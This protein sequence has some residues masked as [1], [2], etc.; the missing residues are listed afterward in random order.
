MRPILA[1]AFLLASSL[2]AQPAKQVLAELNWARQQPKAAAEVLKGW[3]PLFE[4]GR[5]LAFPGEPR[6]RTQEGMA[7]VKEAIAFLEKQKPLPPLS[8]SDRLA[9][10]AEDLARD[11][12]QHGGLGH[13]GS[14]GSLPWDRI[15]R[16][17]T[18]DGGVG[19]VATYGT[20]GEPGDPRRA[21]LALIVDDGVA[22]R[23][24]R[25]VIF[26]PSYTLAGAAWGP[27][28]IYTHMVIVDFATGFLRDVEPRPTQTRR[29]EF[30]KQLVQELNL[31]RQDPKACAAELR[32]W[33]T[34]FQ[35]GRVL[36]FPGERPMQ[37]AEGAP[38]VLEAIALLESRQSVEPV[39]WSEDLAASAEERVIAD[40]DATSTAMNLSTRLARHG[41]LDSPCGE[42]ITY[43]DFGGPH[44][45]RRALLA[46]LVADGAHNRRTLRLLLDPG[47]KRAGAAWDTH[48]QFGAL[49]VLDIAGPMRLIP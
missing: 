17:G 10:S 2:A 42:A 27:H 40:G 41:G 38:A 33:L 14:D 29:D 25:A 44:Y 45:L 12:A 11:Q 5:Y 46:M 20:F 24:H 49:A 39:V 35:P 32:T 16:Y 18:V 3:L 22:D 31:A 23:G 37:T 13:Q 26:D 47:A 36:A 8:W 7:A 19:E 28:P 48:R 9:R 43:G 1:L 34:H 30:A 6:L 21:V 4:G 15:K